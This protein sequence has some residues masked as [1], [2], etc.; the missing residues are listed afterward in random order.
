MKTTDSAQAARDYIDRII[1]INRR[2]G[3]GGDVS[4]D[5]YNRAVEQ[6]E[7]AERVVRVR[8]VNAAPTQ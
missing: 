8:T 1:A 2:H 6:A 3:M 5:T 7:R 4:E